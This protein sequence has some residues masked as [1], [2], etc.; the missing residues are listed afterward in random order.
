[1]TVFA[2]LLVFRGWFP[3]WLAVLFGVVAIGVVFLTYV[4][5]SG[6]VTRG[7]RWLLASIRGLTLASILFLLLKPTLVWDVTN[8][9]LRP[10]AVLV[11]DSQSM[12]V[13]DTRSRYP[14][15]WRLG[16]AYDKIEPA[17]PMPE[18]LS[19]GDI[20][21]GLPEL[22]TRLEVLK[23]ALSNPRLKILER[24]QARG[25]VQPASFG[26]ARFARDPR[27][28]DWVSALAGKEPRTAMVD[29]VL[30]LLRRE[31]SELPSSIVLMTDGRENASAKSLRE[32]ADEAK[33]LRVPLHIYGVGS[34]SLGRL[35]LRDVTLPE[36]MFVEDT[37]SIPVRF[38]SLGHGDSQAEIVVKLNGREVARKVV[39][40][41][42]GDDLRETLS[43]VPTLADAAP[44]KQEVTTSIRLISETVKAGDELVKSSR[45]V[46]RKVKVLVV[47]SIPRWDFKFLQRSLLR[48]RR[49]EARFWL[50]DGDKVAMNGG[51]PF[52]P[53]FP[54]NRE[55]LFAYDLLILGDIPARLLNTVQMEA[56]RDFVAEG[57]GLIHIA[58]RQAAPATF[59]GTILADLLPV[60]VPTQTFPIDSG[61]RP[62][63]FRPE[64]T[65]LG[66]RAAVL[67]LSD[68]VAESSRT[69]RNLP[70]IYWHYPVT[71]LKPAADALVVHPT[72]R[73]ADGKQMPLI[74]SHYYG[75]GTVVFCAFDETWRWRYNEADKFFGR[76]WTQTVYV[77]GVPRTLGTKVTQLS[78]DTPDPVLGK[79]GQLYARLFKPDLTPQT[80]EQVEAVLQRIDAGGDD[81][82]RTTR[83][84][85]RKLPG[86]TGDYSA[87]IPF[88]RTGQFTLTVDNG[89]N[90]A[91]VEYRVSL[92]A[93]HEM[94]P[95]GLQE[96]DLKMLATESGGKYYREENLHDLPETVPFVTTNV[97]QRQ[98][99]VL[100]N[101]WS[102]LWV[103]GLFTLEW[104]LRKF[105]SLS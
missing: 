91:N 29:A 49:V 24:I 92:P 39:N 2:N 22:P 37:V 71:K 79:T 101:V 97:T 34:S 14:D 48:D 8:E 6:R 103:V 65:P 94:A 70:E 99:W 26:T 69:W 98:E 5:E 62:N 60:E 93:D 27:N 54:A 90:P 57:G 12:T 56:I 36:A 58:G 59:N 18:M 76:F 81:K 10:V 52:L 15:Q 4:R 53:A 72:S 66:Q 63:G 17:K 75:K 23:A 31:G 85:L 105:S 35:A 83:L 33:R 1:M 55:E 46:D 20:P 87:P 61:D 44:G 84:T 32:L 40:L 102:L 74:A 7:R 13:K 64:L 89:G 43:F 3:L 38:R 96:E 104:F 78:L 82:D 51:P 41:T 47:D 88:N 21:T 50:S 19:T 95:G 67:R 28:Q 100:W 11:D 16:V 80:A 25:P 9:R 42:D 86:V 68:D 77:A 30:D 45:V 73:M